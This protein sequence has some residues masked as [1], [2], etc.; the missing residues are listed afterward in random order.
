MKQRLLFYLFCL[1][2]FASVARQSTSAEQTV[3]QEQ[4]E[5]Y[6]YVNAYSLTLRA[7]PTASS[8]AVATIG[9]ASRVHVLDT[10]ADGW[11]KV[12]AQDYTDYVKSSYLVDDQQE[13]VAETIDWDVVQANGGTDYTS[14]TAVEATPA[15]YSAPTHAPVRR[16][17]PKVA[18]GPRVYICGNRRTEVYHSSE[19]CSAMRRCTYQT[20]VMSESQA[21]SSGLRECM[22]CY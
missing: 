6:R 14:I 9:G 17:T 7:Q 18:A 13:V 5:V 16:A 1:L 2:S 22:K 10:R 4:T 3:A 15:A 20:L 8:L 21:R 19:G 11:S 12:E